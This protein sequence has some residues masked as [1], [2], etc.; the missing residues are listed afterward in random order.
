LFLVALRN[1]LIRVVAV[2]GVIPPLQRGTVVVSFV[3]LAARFVRSGSAAQRWFARILLVNN[4]AAVLEQG[5]PGL[6]LIEL[7][8]G[9]QILRTGR[10][11]RSNLLLGLG[12]TFRRLG[13]RREGLR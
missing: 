11:N 3:V 4:L 13:M 1:N 2:G 9:H 7:G 10:Q 12:D 6:D 8:S 5:Q